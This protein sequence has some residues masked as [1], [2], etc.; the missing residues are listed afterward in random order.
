MKTDRSGYSMCQK[1]S[2]VF[3]VLLIFVAGVQTGNGNFTLFKSNGTGSSNK[4]LP[5]NL[6]YAEVENIYDQL[7]ARYDGKLSETELLDGLKKGLVAASGDPYTEFM[8]ISEAKEFE[9]Q[10]NG[11]FE[12][13]GAELGKDK[14]AVIIVAPISN[15]PAEKAGLRPK[16]V[17]TEINGKNAIGMSVEE[18]RNKIRGPKGTQ[19]KLTIIR[20]EEELNITITRDT[21]NIASVE[22][23][24]L[25]DQIGYLKISRFADDTA[26]LA[27]QAADKFKQDGAKSVILDLR[28]NPGGYLE[29]AVSVSSLWLQ[30]KIVLQEKRDNVVIKTY[31]SKGSATLASVPTI[32]LID[33][34]SASAS[35]ITAG[36]LHDH[37]VA[38][39]LGVKSFGKGSVQE[40]QQLEDGSLL[41]ITIARWYTPKG[42]NIDKEGISPDTKVDRTVDDY[43]AGRDPQL[44]AAVAKLRK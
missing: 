22:S 10:L 27:Q 42:K 18:A 35:E 8:P 5:A 12:G 37:G 28:G 34:G 44:D 1:L 17:I 20:G 33:E 6:D 7:R 23:K 26:T 36:A 3:L 43:K 24:M 11:S 2:L 14:E 29:S 21:I 19:V 16:D 31:K 39:L 13:I 40:P 9:E 25:D 41:K 32:V 38:S 30:D 15:M 4:N